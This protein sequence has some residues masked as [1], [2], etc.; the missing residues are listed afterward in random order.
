MRYS[1]GLKALSFLLPPPSLTLVGFSSSSSSPLSIS[2][3]IFSTPV[4]L[5]ARVVAR[6]IS[7]RFFLL[8]FMDFGAWF[9]DMEALR[10]SKNTGAASPQSVVELLVAET[11][12]AAERSLLCF[13]LAVRTL[14][15]LTFDILNLFSVS[16]LLKLMIGEAGTGLSWVLSYISGDAF[17]FLCFSGA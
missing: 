15:F 14:L 12:L 5:F 8:I 16:N 6:L 17:T 1:I 2:E 10:G 7:C 4:L 9:V 13:I 3:L 11:V